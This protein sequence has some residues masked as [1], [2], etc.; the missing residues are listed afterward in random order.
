M[1]VTF[2][3]V[4]TGGPGAARQRRDG[5]GLLAIRTDLYASRDWCQREMLIAKRA[6][7][8]VV[9]M[10]ALGRGEERGSFLMDH[11]PRVPLRPSAAGWMRPTSAVA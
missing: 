6:G 4:R 10:D 2:K 9:I 5:G 7:M 1:P 11:V 8:P 3:P